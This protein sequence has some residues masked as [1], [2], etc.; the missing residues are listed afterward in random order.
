MQNAAPLVSLE[1]TTPDQRHLMCASCGYDLFSLAK[2]IACPECGA[3][4]TATRELPPTM[5]GGANRIP[6]ASWLLALLH[7]WLQC[8]FC[9]GLFSSLLF[10]PLVIGVLGAL[11]VARFMLGAA[12]AAVLVMDWLT[13]DREQRPTWLVAPVLLVADAILAIVPYLPVTVSLDLLDIVNIAV[14]V[15]VALALKAMFLN[16][17]ALL[18][19]EQEIRSIRV[20]VWIAVL[21]LIGLALARLLPAAP[22]GLTRMDLSS[23]LWD[24][25]LVSVQFGRLLMPLVIGIVLIL[26][27]G[28]IK[29]L[30]RRLRESVPVDR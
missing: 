18:G 11:Q 3:Q 12:F 29:R 24:L 7:N 27:C 14:L 5:A 6:R 23:Q 1:P 28:V 15:G 21:A 10:F 26:A 4:P 20:L 30:R 22:R 9:V 16:V 13:T 19:A 17:A 2:G 8:Q 25:F